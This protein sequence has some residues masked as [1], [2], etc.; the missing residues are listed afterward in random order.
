MPCCFVSQ[1]IQ[2]GTLAPVAWNNL[3]PLHS[4][5]MTIGFSELCVSSST[6]V[7]LHNW[8]VESYS[9]STV[10]IPAALPCGTPV[11]LSSLRV[12]KDLAACVSLP[13]HGLLL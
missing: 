12:L 7:S 8:H 11:V 6:I 4:H 3:L 5:F 13:V 10:H 2:L 1:D 9:S